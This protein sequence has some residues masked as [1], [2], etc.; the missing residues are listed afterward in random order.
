[1]GRKKIEINPECGKRLLKLLKKHNIQQKE[2]AKALNY[3]PQ[4]ISRIVTGRDNFTE[5]F[6]CKIV[7][8]FRNCDRD[9][10][11]YE[12]VRLNWLM[13]RDN[14]ETEGERIHSISAGKDEMKRLILRLIQLHGYD[15]KIMECDPWVAQIGED[16]ISRWEKEGMQDRLGQYYE[17]LKKYNAT[18]YK[19]IKYTIESHRQDRDMIYKV[20]DHNEIERIFSDISGFVEFT[21]GKYLKRPCSSH[22]HTNTRKGNGN[23]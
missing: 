18:P 14:F 1:M 8:F 4:Q 15:L 2:L 3:T 12:V 19:E 22:F 5:E 23:G 7:E 16:T 9:H 17:E 20:L 11:L 6:A 13:C 21:C 10:D